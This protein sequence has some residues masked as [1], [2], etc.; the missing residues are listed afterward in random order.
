MK[1][2]NEET[3]SRKIRELNK[4]SGSLPYGEQRKCV[5]SQI[6]ALKWTRGESRLV[7]FKKEGAK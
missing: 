1:A 5:V 6:N 2:P 3:V 4:L 7:V